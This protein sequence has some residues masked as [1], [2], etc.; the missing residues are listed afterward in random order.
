MRYYN[1]DKQPLHLIWGA[2]VALAV[3]IVGVWFFGTKFTSIYRDK[4]GVAGAW[5]ICCVVLHILGA[6]LLLLHYKIILQ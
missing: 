3:P 1:T 2:L 5:C 4:R 6:F